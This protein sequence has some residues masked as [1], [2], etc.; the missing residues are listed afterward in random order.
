[1]SW[2]TRFLN[3]TIGLKALMAVSGLLLFGFVVGHMVGNLQIFLGPEA[4]NEYAEMLQGMAEVL[5]PVSV[6]AA[7]LAVEAI[8]AVGPGGHFFGSPHTMERY[9]TAFYSRC[10]RT[11]AISRAGRRPARWMRP[12]GRT[13]STESSSRATRNRRSTPP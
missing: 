12:T 4:I 8:E 5:R 1:M 2:L 6:S 11:G 13:G 10:S 7:D 9:E 3:S